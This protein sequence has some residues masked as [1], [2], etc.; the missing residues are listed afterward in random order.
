MAGPDPDKPAGE[1]F[2]KSLKQLE[3]ES[4]ELKAKIEQ[5][6]D[7]TICRSTPNS[8]IPSGKR[9]PKTAASIVLR[10]RTKNSG[11]ENNNLFLETEIAG[12]MALT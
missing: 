1:D 9:K 12:S 5:E 8:A 10:T 2:S 4:N 11:A 7:P 3:E 6:N